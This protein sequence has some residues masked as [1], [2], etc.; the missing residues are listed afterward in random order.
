ML[1]T[2]IAQAWT[3]VQ[4]ALPYQSPKIPHQ[5]SQPILRFPSLIAVW[6]CIWLQ[7]FSLVEFFSYLLPMV[8]GPYYGKLHL[9][10]MLLLSTFLTTLTID[11]VTMRFVITFAKFV[12]FVK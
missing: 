6:F 7:V 5:K 1:A 11:L 4:H 3:S 12:G 10:L 9:H 8:L 2:R